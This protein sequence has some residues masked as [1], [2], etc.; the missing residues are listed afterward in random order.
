MLKKIGVLTSGGDAPGMN[1]AIAAVIKAAIAKGIEPYIVRDGYKGL[2][3]GWFEKVDL[4]FAGNII[5]RG[6]T[7]IGSARLPEFK[8][9][10]V[11]EKAIVKLKEA[12]LEAL[13]VIG[14]DGSYQGAQKLTDMGVNCIGLP[15][16]IDNDIASSD[17]TIGFDTALNTVVRSIDAIRDTMESHNRCAVVEIMGNSCGDLALYAATATGVDVFSTS[18]SKLTE[19]E[20]IKQV[21]DLAANNKRSVI[22]AVS[23]NMYDVHQ[24]AKDVEKESGYVTRATVLGHVQRGGV[25]SAMDRFLATTAG[26]YAV[27]QLSI[28]KG[29]LYIGQDG[30]KLIA[31]DINS[32]LNMPRVNREELTN[33]IRKIN[34][35]FKR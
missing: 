25:P 13:V 8:D 11:R 29:G 26:I 19:E 4:S 12:Q 33:E 3:N 17:Y 10:A 21:K 20:I 24:L 1:A 15:G 14:G 22:V 31:R 2:I 6:G 23:E 18:E 9:V 32:T 27:E 16:T 7:V 34:D 35:P 30:Q 28:G 5:S